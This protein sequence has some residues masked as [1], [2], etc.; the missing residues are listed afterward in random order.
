MLTKVSKTD[1]ALAGAPFRSQY[2]I[3]Q[4]L[5]T[6]S[7]AH[8]DGDALSG[9]LPK[10]FLEA[11][12]K[13]THEVDRSRQDKDNAAAEAKLTTTQQDANVRLLKVWRRRVASR[14]SRAMRLGEDIPVELTLIGR[15]K[16]VT[17]VLEDASTKTR[18]L[19]ENKAKLESAT[20]AGVQALLE[21][22]QALYQALSDADVVQEAKRLAALPT[23]V[24]DY[25]A[26]KGELYMAVKAINDAGRELHADE[27]AHL[28][29]YNLRILHRRAG[30]RAPS[31]PIQPAPAPPVAPS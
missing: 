21:E 6:I 3:Q 13:C 10:G 29:K 24:Q 17:E 14:A 25:F 7:I 26:K 18:L 27:P 5:Y 22:G 20:G 30:T 9:L 12:E 11:A 8:G 4:A 1:L 23:S 15:A 31:L 16:S 19:T 28:A 2:L